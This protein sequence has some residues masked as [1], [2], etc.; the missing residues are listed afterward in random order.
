MS[1]QRQ[2][3]KLDSA[4]VADWRYVSLVLLALVRTFQVLLPL[5]VQLSVCTEDCDRGVASECLGQLLLLDPQDVLPSLAALFHS[6]HRES[7]RT[8]LACIRY[9]RP[10]SLSPRLSLSLL[11]A[12]FVLCEGSVVFSGPERIVNRLPRCFSSFRQGPVHSFVSC[13][14]P[15]VC[16]LQARTSGG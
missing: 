12:L 8:A 13:W 6:P 1:K 2:R 4:R 11:S 7:R 5:L 3:C 14:L 10:A 16:I 15:G 9:A